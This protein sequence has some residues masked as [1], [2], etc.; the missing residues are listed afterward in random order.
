M[1]PALTNLQG[2]RFSAHTNISPAGLIYQQVRGRIDF[3]RRRNI[4]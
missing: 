3:P 1:K 2:R 4:L